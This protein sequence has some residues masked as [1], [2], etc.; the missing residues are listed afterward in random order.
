[1]CCPVASPSA[2]GVFRELFRPVAPFLVHHLGRMRLGGAGT[3][4]PKLYTLD[5]G[6]LAHEC[7]S[8]LSTRVGRRYSLTKGA[9][10]FGLEAVL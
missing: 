5:A 7:V 9:T 3:P 1:M 2:V 4:R 8:Q 6:L 10:T